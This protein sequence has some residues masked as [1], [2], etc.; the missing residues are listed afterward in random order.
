MT[1]KNKS[2]GKVFVFGSNLAGNHFNGAAKYA[3]DFKGAKQGKGE[4][5]SG[6]SYAIPTQIYG[7]DRRLCWLPIATIEKAVG[8]FLRYAARNPNEV[9]QVTPIATGV[10][11]YSTGLIANMFKAAPENCELPPP[12][13]KWRD[14]HQMELEIENQD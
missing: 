11:G 14:K 7:Q 1:P 3:F 10:G 8:R 12:W 13:I 4:G 9:F 2:P 5:R 6:D